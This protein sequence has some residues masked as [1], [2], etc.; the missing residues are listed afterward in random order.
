MKYYTIWHNSL[1]CELFL[2]VVKTVKNTH[3]FTFY[4]FTAKHVTGF[5]VNM[6]SQSDLGVAYCY[7]INIKEANS[8]QIEYAAAI[9]VR[10]GSKLII[11]LKKI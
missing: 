2:E 7:E 1:Q 10:S 8:S 9:E 4:Q 11:F 6:L 5:T 3:K